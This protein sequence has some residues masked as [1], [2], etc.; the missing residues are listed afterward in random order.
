MQHS[1]AS[2]LMLSCLP[3]LHLRTAQKILRPCKYQSEKLW[4][5]PKNLNNR[6]TT[7]MRM[8]D[9]KFDVDWRD[10][11]FTLFLRQ[12]TAELVKSSLH[13]IK[14]WIFASAASG[15]CPTEWRSR[16]TF[17]PSIRDFAPQRHL[18]P[19]RKKERVTSTSWWLFDKFR[20]RLFQKLSSFRW[21]ATAR[22]KHKFIKGF[23]GMVGGVRTQPS[24][25]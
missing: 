15:L 21:K 9:W 2:V 12:T 17:A 20:E 16:W 25:V 10:E 5:Y 19:G 7:A 8:T 3:V 11:T 6:R 14:S 13:R 18:R 1:E 4:E 22:R 24:K 23:F